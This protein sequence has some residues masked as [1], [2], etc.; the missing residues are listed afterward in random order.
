MTLQALFDEQSRLWNG[1]AGQAWVQSQALLDALFAP[2][3]ALLLDG[4]LGHERVLD[5][6]CGTGATTLA[7]ARRQNAG[8]VGVDVSA[9]MT[10]LAQARAEREGSR[11]RFV[12]A[13]AQSHAFEPASFD[14]LISRF[15]VMFFADPQAAFANLRRAAS[16]TAKLRLIVWRSAAENPFMTL[17]E[18]TAAPWLPE[19]PVRRP[20][21]PGQFAFAEALRVRELLTAS[22]WEGVEI[23]ALDVPLS[24]PESALVPYLSR[25]GPVGIALQELEEGARADLIERLRAAFAPFVRG[26]R[27]EFTAACWLVEAQA[28]RFA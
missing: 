9:P 13:D 12:C 3:E 1:A 27:V 4:L 15:G 18:R 19:L 6:G 8:C 14:R 17:A 24:M 20:G 26:E 10:T 11:A 23:R 21:A 2:L 28:G 7:A 25:L 22:G 5:I 16:D